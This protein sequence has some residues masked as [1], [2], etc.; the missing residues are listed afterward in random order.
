M[1]YRYA[2]HQSLDL[3]WR[4]RLAGNSPARR[5]LTAIWSWM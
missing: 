2:I 1:K 5:W 4:L 3:R